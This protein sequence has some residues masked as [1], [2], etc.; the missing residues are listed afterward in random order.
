VSRQYG[1]G[2]GG[3]AAQQVGELGDDSSYNHQLGGYP[4]QALKPQPESG[5]TYTW[6]AQRLASMGVGK[7][8]GCQQSARSMLREQAEGLRRKAANLEALASSI[9]DSFPP[10]A[11]DALR[12][13][14]VNMRTY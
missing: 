6:A 9:P 11:D 3:V 1:E 12:S 14:V 8:A 7:P 10:G 13:L 4:N 5:A 2:A